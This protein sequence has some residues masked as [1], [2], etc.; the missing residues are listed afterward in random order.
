[1][2]KSDLLIIGMSPG[3]SYF[4]QNNINKL[5]DYATSM[6]ENIEIFIPDIPAVATYIALGYPENIARREKAIPQGNTFRNRIR[7]YL[8][9]KTTTKVSIFDWKKENI[10]ENIKYQEY[11]YYLKNLYNTNIEFK[12]DIYDATFTVITDNPFRKKEIVE[13]DIEIGTHYI[14]SEFSFMLFLHEIRPSFI[15]FYYGYHNNWPVFEK[16]INGFY[17]GKPKTNLKFI[18]LPNFSI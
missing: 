17:D 1:M 7:K 15:N 9:N 8:N 6:F 2:N 11:Y 12:K 16:F 18:K 3:N 5:L 13:K 4:K 10:E 14:I